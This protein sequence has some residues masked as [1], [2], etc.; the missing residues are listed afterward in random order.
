[1]KKFVLIIFW[2][3]VKKN[4]YLHLIV[5]CFVQNKCDDNNFDFICFLEFLLFLGSINGLWPMWRI[6]YLCMFDRDIFDVMYTSMLN[7]IFRWFD[8][9]WPF[10][11]IFTHP[12]DLMLNYF[13]LFD[14]VVHVCT[15]TVLQCHPLSSRLFC[16]HQRNLSTPQIIVT[17]VRFTEW[18]CSICVGNNLIWIYRHLHAHTDTQTHNRTFRIKNK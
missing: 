15:P 6:I 11:Y 1:V 14:Q 4:Y 10:I 12:F 3:C 7:A 8:N 9:N 16:V 5:I 18:M 17:I 13:L 2:L